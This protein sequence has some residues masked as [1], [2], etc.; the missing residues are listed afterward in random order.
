PVRRPQ[1]IEHAVEH[2]CGALLRPV[3]WSSS[4][5]GITDML[6]QGK[7]GA[8]PFDVEDIAQRGAESKTGLCQPD[9]MDMGADEVFVCHIQPWG[10][11]RTSHHQL[12]PL[13]EIL[14]VWTKGGTVRKHQGRLAT[15]SSTSTT[16]CIVS[17][18]GWHVAQIHD[19]EFSDVH[20]QLHGGGAV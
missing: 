3:P 15:A 13:E 11:Q 17:G 18:R 19:V 9:G 12:G 14:V 2:P 7:R 10:R 8:L 20:P 1:C 4:R 5:H 16:L 6:L